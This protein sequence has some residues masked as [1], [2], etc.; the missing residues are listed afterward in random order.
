MKVIEKWLI[1]LGL[2]FIIFAPSLGVAQENIELVSKGT[3]YNRAQVTQWLDS[4]KF[5]VG[6]WDGTISIFRQPSSQNE[7]GPVLT[8]V[9]NSPSGKPLEMAV[10]IADGMF[11]TSNDSGSIAVWGSSKA[12]YDLAGIYSYDPQYGTA[13][14]ASLVMIDNKQWLVTG[15]SEGFII[16][17]E[18]TGNKLTMMKAVSVRSPTPILSPYKL[19]NVRSVILWK[20]GIVVTG[21]EDGDICMIKI[22]DGTIISRTRYNQF[23]QRGIN[24]LSLNNDYLLLANC[25]VG[26]T[27]KNLWL[28]KIQGKEIISLDSINLAKDTSLPQ[29]FD[30]DAKL[31]SFKD[32]IYF[33]ASTQEGILWMG[34]VEK[35]KL[36]IITNAKVSSDGGAAIAFQPQSWMIAVVA[37][38]IGLYTASGLEH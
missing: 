28:Y 8:Q 11:A 24:Q 29:I 26:K 5:I 31:A 25:S 6:R 3:T 19:W 27:D 13:N 35:D 22:P 7:Y 32:K 2:C 37:F 36:N 38:D 14:S 21:A 9:F 18:L 10:S 4:N 34:A 30:F 17:W 15:H 20:Q 1:S 33:F 12:K 23:A 16:I